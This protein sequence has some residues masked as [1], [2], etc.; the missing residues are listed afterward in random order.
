MA[1]RAW[2]TTY[3]PAL[4]NKTKTA[5]MECDSK[6]YPNLWVADAWNIRARWAKNKWVFLPLSATD[7]RQIWGGHRYKMAINLDNT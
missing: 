7:E 4:K 1:N 6:E 5:L 2:G 3:K